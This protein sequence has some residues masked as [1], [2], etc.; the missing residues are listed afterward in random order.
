MSFIED[1][2][3]DITRGCWPFTCYKAVFRNWEPSAFFISRHTACK[4]LVNVFFVYMFAKLNDSRF[5]WFALV[6]NVETDR[7]RRSRRPSG[8]W[9]TDRKT[10]EIRPAT[11]QLT[12]IATN[13]TDRATTKRKWPSRPQP[14]NGENVIYSLWTWS[15]LEEGGGD[16]RG[17]DERTVP[18]LRWDVWISVEQHHRASHRHDK[19]QDLHPD[20][21]G[22][23]SLFTF[24][25]VR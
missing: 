16:D 6:V 12:F 4:R 3:A 10:V 1:W 20:R 21:N 19:R 24:Y 14:S 11:S 7:A 8:S 13:V 23:D 15:D 25:L 5:H 2:R 9:C 17:E 18:D 22:N